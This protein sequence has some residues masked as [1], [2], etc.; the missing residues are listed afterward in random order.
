MYPIFDICNDNAL[1]SIMECGTAIHP[2]NVTGKVIN[3]EI[4][5]KFYQQIISTILV[6]S[7]VCI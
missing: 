2:A 1:Q 4:L 6:D 7:T 3:W 5:V